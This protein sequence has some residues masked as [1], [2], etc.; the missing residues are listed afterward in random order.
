MSSSVR[1]C[2]FTKNNCNCKNTYTPC[3]KSMCKLSYQLDKSNE[4]YVNSEIDNTYIPY[5][6]SNEPNVIGEIDDTC[7]HYIKKGYCLH[8]TKTGKICRF[9][10]PLKFKSELTPDIPLCWHRSNCKH[11]HCKFSHDTNKKYI[12]PLCWHGQHCKFYNCIFLHPEDNGKPHVPPMCWNH[13][14]KYYLTGNCTHKDYN[15][16]PCKFLHIRPSEILSHQQKQYE[17]LTSYSHEMYMQSIYAMQM[18]HHWIQ[19]TIYPIQTVF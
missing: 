18:M 9:S 6:E 7:R 1:L 13:V 16:E 11:P 8:K 12:P 4:P 10:H 3:S 14:C 5:S 17:M 2:N 19:P 15:A